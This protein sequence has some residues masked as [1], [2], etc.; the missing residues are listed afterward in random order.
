[1]FST[2][3]INNRVYQPELSAYDGQ[4]VDILEELEPDEFG[5]PVYR[6]QCRDGNIIDVADVFLD[7]SN[8]GYLF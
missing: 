1:M 8:T 3:Y 4:A 7:S 2:M 5:S 6:V